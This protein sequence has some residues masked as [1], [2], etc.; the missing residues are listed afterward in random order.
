M[1]STG[2][3]CPRRR[4]MCMDV[5]LLSL[6]SGAKAAQGLTVIIDVFRAFSVECYLY[7]Q[8]VD[9][10]FALSEQSRAIALK[11][12]HPSYVSVGERDGIQLEGFDYGNSPKQIM[13]ACNLL[14]KTVIHTTSAGTKGIIAAKGASE[15]I[16]GSFVNAKAIARYIKKR[17]PDTVSLVAMGYGGELETR[18]DTVCAEYLRALL[19]DEPFDLSYVKN[20]LRYQ[21]G[22]RFFQPDRQGSEPKEDF[23]LC[24]EFNCFDFV[25]RAEKIEEGLYYMERVN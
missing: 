22:N 24:L 1:L 2:S 16:T 13:E 23:D 11:E 7:H 10:I 19:L 3:N 20:T 5:R 9:K 4:R 15:I 17:K 21:G 12:E 6:L 8:G 25:I 14:G 18:E